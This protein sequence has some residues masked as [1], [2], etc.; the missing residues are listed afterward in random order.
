MI[1][2]DILPDNGQLEPCSDDLPYNGFSHSET[3][4]DTPY[5]PLG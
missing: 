3:D 2:S 5:L 1:S 4:P